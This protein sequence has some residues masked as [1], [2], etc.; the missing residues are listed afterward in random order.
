MEAITQGQ[1]NPSRNF[2]PSVP[3]VIHKSYI[4]VPIHVDGDVESLTGHIF[5]SF[6]T[7][8][9]KNA[10]TQRTQTQRQLT[11]RNRLCSPYVQRYVATWQWNCDTYNGD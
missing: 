7:I 1:A 9:V 6:R 3:K 5:A 10:L 8:I 11:I 2:G 4:L